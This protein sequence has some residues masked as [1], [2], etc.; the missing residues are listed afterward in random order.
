[1]RRPHFRAAWLRAGGQQAEGEDRRPPEAGPW[2]WVFGSSEVAGQWQFPRPWQQV[3]HPEG[4]VSQQIEGWDRPRQTPGN[5]RDTRGQ[6]SPKPEI[7][8]LG[9]QQE[10]AAGRQGTGQGAGA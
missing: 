1:M 3:G 2:L 4:P 10:G 6:Q 9:T 7:Q 8:Q 5:R